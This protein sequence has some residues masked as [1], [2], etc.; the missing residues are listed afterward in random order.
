[1]EE[2]TGRRSDL[3]VQAEIS[4]FV[5]YGSHTSLRTI[6]V[7]ILPALHSGLS[8][9]SATKAW[10]SRGRYLPSFEIERYLTAG[11]ERSLVV[12][13]R[14]SGRPI[15]LVELADYQPIERRGHLSV[16]SWAR[17]LQRGLVVE[18]IAMALDEWFATAGLD[19]VHT[20]SADGL[21]GSYRR[22]MDSFFT[23]DG[24]LRGYLS[25]D[26]HLHDVLL[27]SL[28]RDEF[29]DRLSKSRLFGACQTWKS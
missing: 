11:V 1:M 29:V 20:M 21:M 24:R 9:L 19:R 14:R 6:G 4:P 8:D 5:R 17:G 22:A 7:D 26:D 23:Y 18:G 25:I 16:V 15:G 12:C 10:R 2:A 3:A 28:A 13:L 27:Y